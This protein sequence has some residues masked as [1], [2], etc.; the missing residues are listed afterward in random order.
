MFKLSNESK[1]ALLAIA[2]VAL[3]IWGFQ[4]LKGIDILSSS[5]TFY[6]RYDNVDQLRASSPVFIRGLQVGTVKDLYID[7]ADD[8]TIIAELDIQP[9]VE[10][11]KNAIA[12]IVGLTL[13]GGKAIEIVI[14]TPCS[15][16]DCAES[17]SYLQGSSRSFLQ[18][19]VGEPG[20][21][22]AYTERIRAGLAINL[23]SLARVH[24]NGLAGT[25]G[26]VN[27]TVQE[28]EA[29][30]KIM[31]EIVRENRADMAQTLDY[32]K[33]ITRGMSDSEK[34]ISALIA[35]LND[36]SQK[37][38]SE[39][40]DQGTQK[41]VAAIDSV[42]ASLSA[43]KGTMFAAE[44]TLSRVDTLAQ[45]LVQGKG[46]AGKAL[47]D[48]EMYDNLLRTSRHLHLLLQDLRLNPKRYTTVKLKLFGKN[49]T[50]GYQLPLDDPAYLHLVDSLE[51][52]YSRKVRR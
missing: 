45:G 17:G 20:Q 21:I 40:F 52:D 30:S 13:M 7:K 14:S 4:F 46:L 35:N 1:I 26:S 22:D 48:E 47:N 31:K 6:V 19:V 39:Q 34:G 42:T 27:N 12:T 37:L 33:E 49:K 25:L 9:S 10:I 51:R 36:V 18:S 43:L 8:K 38:K 2:A 41:A 23:D 15:G 44:R 28:L 3:A 16:K 32:I 24:P 50:K 5:Q 29:M 11:P